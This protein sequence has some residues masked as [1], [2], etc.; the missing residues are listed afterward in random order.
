[1]ARSHPMRQALETERFI[2]K[3]LGRVEAYRI[4]RGN[5]N[6]DQEMMRNLIYS[7]EPLNPWRWMRKMVWVNG[8]SKFS[9][10]IL[11][12]SGGQ[13]I[14]IHGVT[15]QRHRSAAMVVAIHDREWWGQ[16]VVAEIR[17]AVIDHAF[18]CRVTDRFCC[19]VNARNVASIFNY[20]KL[21]FN[22]VGTL[23]KAQFDPVSGELFD[24]LIFEL[25]RGDWEWQRRRDV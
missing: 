19:S 5:W 18:E 24:T 16:K 3:P 20:K 9:H 21:G 15:L 1:M 10:A 8:R 6:H 11:P 25:L 4:G 14:G 23:H 22:H 2:L 13:P 12:K 7:A 17:R